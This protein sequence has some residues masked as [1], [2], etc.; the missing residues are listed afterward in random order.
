M[1]GALYLGYQQAVAYAEAKVLDQYNI[2]PRLFE[3]G[4][5]GMSIIGNETLTT[6]T[7]D[8]D[9][10]PQRVVTGSSLGSRY[11]KNDFLGRKSDGRMIVGYGNRGMAGIPFDSADFM[12]ELK[13]MPSATVRD[14]VMTGSTGLSISGHSLGSITVAYLVGNGLSSRGYAFAPGAGKAQP[15]DVT[16][17]VSPGDA[18]NLFLL[19]R[20]ANPSSRLCNLPFL[21]HAMVR[22]DQGCQ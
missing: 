16:T 14:W 6:R 12:L 15:P 7:E 3:I 11:V 10:R 20:L 8:D 2:D 5:M 18:A 9:E 13:G 1:V 19:G 22:Y 21:A 17:T 4:L